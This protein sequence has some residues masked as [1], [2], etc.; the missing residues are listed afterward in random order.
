M[1]TPRVSDTISHGRF[2]PDFHKPPLAKLKVKLMNHSFTQ[3]PRNILHF[4]SADCEF[5]NQISRLLLDLKKINHLDIK[6]AKPEVGGVIVTSKCK[7]KVLSAMLKKK[8]FEEFS[9]HE[10]K[11]VLEKK[12]LHPRL[13]YYKYFCLQK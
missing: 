13:P 2:Y 6:N 10:L 12:T 4:I 3:K 5:S 7:F 11:E 8:H 1:N 9:E